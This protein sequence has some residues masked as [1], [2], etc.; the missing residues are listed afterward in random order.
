LWIFLIAEMTEYCGYYGK[1]V[2]ACGDPPEE[3]KVSC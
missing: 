2:W 1:F 3:W